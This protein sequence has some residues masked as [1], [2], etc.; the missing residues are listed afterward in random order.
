MKLFTIGDS[1]SHGFMSGA[2]AKTE[3]CYSTLIAQQLGIKNYQYPTWPKE[4]MPVNI[5]EVFRRL[6]KAYGSGISTLEWVH[7][8]AKTIPAYLNEVEKYY[9]R[10]KGAADQPYEGGQ[11]YFDN[12]AVRGFNVSDSWLMTPKYC[13]KQIEANR[14]RNGIY[15]SV[16]NSFL[17]TALR[18]LNPQLLPEHDKKSQLD[19][20]KY[21]SDKEGVENVI[22]WLG[23]NNALGTIVDLKVHFTKGKGEITNA[24]SDTLQMKIRKFITFGIQKILKQITGNYSTE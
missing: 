18:V 5:E 3:L 4:G 11:E 1:I 6:E 14:T 21:H 10:G 15:S 2:A 20:L 16:D 12:V 23:A 7:A 9:E 22:I 24:P 17:R 8:L 19:W 13:K